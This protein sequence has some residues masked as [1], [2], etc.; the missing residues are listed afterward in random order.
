M[1]WKGGGS[2]RGSRCPSV[3]KHTTHSIASP[4]DRLHVDVSLPIFEL[5]GRRFGSSSGNISGV[6]GISGYSV[7]IVLVSRGEAFAV[8]LVRFITEIWVAM[9][10]YGARAFLLSRTS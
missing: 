8:G 6:S 9:E 4:N 2:D 10:A 7:I 5:V 1:E 3:A